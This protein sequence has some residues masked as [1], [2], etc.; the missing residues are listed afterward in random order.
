[1]IPWPTAAS[2]TCLLPGWI[3]L[4]IK[5][6]VFPQHCIKELSSHGT[7]VV[8]IFLTYVYMG[9]GRA[10]PVSRWTHQFAH[11]QQ[12]ISKKYH[13]ERSDLW[14]GDCAPL[15]IFDC[16]IKNFNNSFMSF[17][18]PWTDTSKYRHICCTNVLC[19]GVYEQNSIANVSS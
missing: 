17:Q 2:S 11:G 19:W 15:F 3:Q 16:Y 14:W 5:P 10:S 7:C 4:R 1:M 9:R 18:S 13:P 12:E 6:S 8:S